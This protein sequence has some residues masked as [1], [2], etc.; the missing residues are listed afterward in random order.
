MAVGH[1]ASFHLGSSSSLVEVGS[2]LLFGSVAG[3]DIVNHSSGSGSFSHTRRRALM[4]DDVRIALPVCDPALHPDRE[5]IFA[6]LGRR[7]FC[8]DRLLDLLIL[9]SSRA[10]WRRSFGGCRRLR[11]LTRQDRCQK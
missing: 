6:D 9:L 2:G 8:P 1:V 4:L 7:E 11:R 5:P 10:L 3:F